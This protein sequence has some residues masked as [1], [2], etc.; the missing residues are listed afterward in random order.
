MGTQ[1]LKPK[2]TTAQALASAAGQTACFELLENAQRKSAVV[3][4]KKNEVYEMSVNYE[5]L[6]AQLGIY[7]EAYHLS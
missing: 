6:Q 7:T 4:Y 5:S 2:P 1:E 3:T